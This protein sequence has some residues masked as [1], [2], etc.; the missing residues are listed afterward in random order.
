M[1]TL[2]QITP[3]NKKQYTGSKAKDTVVKEVDTVLVACF[4][5]HASGCSTLGQLI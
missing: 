1:R 3:I 2:G 4:S 5:G